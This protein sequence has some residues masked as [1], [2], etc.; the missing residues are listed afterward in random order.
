MSMLRLLHFPL[1]PFSRKVRLV[2][3]EKELD[4]ELE[5][6][7]PWRCGDELSVLNPAGEVPVLLDGPTAA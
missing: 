6:I 5:A 2:L 7:E 3:R 1:C 4:A